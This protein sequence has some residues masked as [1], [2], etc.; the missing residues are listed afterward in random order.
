MTAFPEEFTSVVSELKGVVKRTWEWFFC[1][2]H[3]SPIPHKSKIKRELL[4]RDANEQGNYLADIKEKKENFVR[5]IIL[6]T[7]WLET[8]QV[9]LKGKSS[10]LVNLIHLI[11]TAWS[12]Q[13]ISLP[14]W[15]MGGFPLM[16]L[17]FYNGLKFFSLLFL[18]TVLNIVVLYVTYYKNV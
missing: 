15:D 4:D 18:F 2:K 14:S 1:K 5:N 6:V 11:T 12:W 7:Q 16:D 17:A 8:T 3:G 10:N 13:L 9:G